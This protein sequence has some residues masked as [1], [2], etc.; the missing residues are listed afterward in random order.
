MIVAQPAKKF[1]AFHETHVSKDAQPRLYPQPGYL[2]HS[3]RL[4]FINIT[5]LL[6]LHPILHLPIDVFHLEFSK[7]VCMDFHLSH[8]SRATIVPLDFIYVIKCEKETYFAIFPRLLLSPFSQIQTF[9]TNSCS[10][11]SPSSLKKRNQ[12]FRPHKTTGKMTILY[13]LTFRVLDEA[14]R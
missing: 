11:T 14:G 9:S 2:F 1:H 3:L 6:Y 4:H 7:K 13:I 10:R 12:V 8:R 5:L